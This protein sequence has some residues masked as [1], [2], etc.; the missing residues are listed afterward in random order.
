MLNIWFRT[1]SA[2]KSW[3]PLLP[4]FSE[5]WSYQVSASLIY[6]FKNQIS[7]WVWF[8]GPTS[9]AYTALQGKA[10]GESKFE[11]EILLKA[12]REDAKKPQSLQIY[13]NLL[14]ASTFVRYWPSQ[15]I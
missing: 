4:F 6:Y 2:H 3:M 7:D 13:T 9:H 14:T 5:Y 11:D 15:L 8:V 1:I 12:C 10:K